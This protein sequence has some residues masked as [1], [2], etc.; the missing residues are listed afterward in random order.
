MDNARQQQDHQAV[1]VLPAAVFAGD[2]MEKKNSHTGSDVRGAR[3]H[4]D[5]LS[6][7]TNK[8]LVVGVSSSAVTVLRFSVSEVHRYRVKPCQTGPQKNA[9]MCIYQRPGI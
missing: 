3:Q 4:L 5:Q 9:P 6:K 2:L 7:Q 1:L 8:H